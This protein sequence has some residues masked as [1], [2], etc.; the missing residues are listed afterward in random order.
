MIPAD[1]L[2]DIARLSDDQVSGATALLRRGVDL[3]KKA[4]GDRSQLLEVAESLCR[5]Q[6]SMA[7]FRTAAALVAASPDPERALDQLSERVRRGPAAI[8]RFAVPLIRLRAAAADR[9][10]IVTCSRSEAV[11]RTLEALA[12]REPVRVCC[13]ESRPGCE[14]V[15]LA[16]ALASKGLEVHVYSDAAIGRALP[17]ADALVVGAD[18][19]S[20]AAF[21][22]KV[23]TAGLCSL[24]H[25]LGIP[26]HVLAGSEKILPHNIFQML[27][28]RTAPIAEVPGR[29][30]FV[31]NPLFE[32]TPTGWV[33]HIVTDRG[34]LLPEDIQRIRMW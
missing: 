25:L 31:Q 9:L 29:P 1:L 8:A 21:I 26:V 12:G 10:T 24:A 23:G 11:E 18:A 28:L 20:E 30:Y 17:T 4:A 14:G 16:G 33:S 5:A 34:S 15:A 7:G 13:A 3:M 32:R 22:N 19:I 2:A 6:P 27:T